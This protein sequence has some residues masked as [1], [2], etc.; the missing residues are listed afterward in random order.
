GAPLNGQ[1]QNLI[2]RDPVTGAI[3]NVAGTAQNIARTITEGL[4]YKA[5][6]QL[7]TSIFGR[8]DFGTFTF[9]LNGNSLPGHRFQ[10]TPAVHRIDLTGQFLGT[11]PGNGA[12]AQNR[13]YAS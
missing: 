13:W 12:L 8:G 7:D 11:I 6:Y 1:F 3:L 2:T 9:I 10:P 4:D 5:I